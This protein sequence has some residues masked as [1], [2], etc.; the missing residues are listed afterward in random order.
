MIG[1]S[2]Q[3]R[4]EAKSKAANLADKLVPYTF[5]GSLIS[6]ALTRNAARVLSV[7]MTSPVR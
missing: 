5:A 1:Q 6:F 7:L 2:E 4:S 3:M